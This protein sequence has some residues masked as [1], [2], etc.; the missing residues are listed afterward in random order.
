MLTEHG[1]VLVAL[2]D[3]QWLDPSSAGVLQIA[4]RRLRDEPVGVLATLRRAPDLAAPFELERTFPEGRL[5]LLE[6]RP[7]SLSAV[8]SLLEQRL[9]LELT[10][11]ELAR[12][13]E[14]TAGNPFFALE[15]GRELVRTGTRPAPGQPLRVPESLQEL[16]GG[17]L[18][19]LP[20][21]TLDVLL[22]V[23]AL[24]RPTVEVVTAAYGDREPVLRSFEE[25]AEEGVLVLD[26]ADIRFAHPLLA[27]ICYERAPLWK[28]R[29]VHRALAGVVT[30]VEERARHLALASEGPDA[31]IAADLDAAAEHAAARGATAAA[32]GLYE[33]AAELTPSD[34][35]LARKRRLRAANFH[36]LSGEQERAV[37][38]L[39]QLLAEVPP[40]VER[41]D[42]LF[43][44]ASV[45]KATI[46]T[47]IELCEE[48][49]TNAAGDD[50]RSARILALRGLFHFNEPNVQAYLADARAALEKAERAG[51]PAL[52]ATAIAHAGH[53]ETWAAE[54]TPGLLERGAEIEGRLGLTLE[55]TTSPRT[56]LARLLM[57]LGEI[58]RP[59]VML[60]ELEAGASARGDE[61]TRAHVLWYLSLLEWLAGRWQLALDHAT[62]ADEAGLDRRRGWWV[63]RVKA[64]IEAD[65]GLV[66]EAR[67]SA[68]VGLAAAHAGS[69]EAFRILTLGV[70][71]RLELARGNLE[72]A[73]SYL[74]DLPGWLLAGGMNDPTLPVWA[75]AIETLVA[76]GE[77][78]Q[79]G[80]YLEPLRVTCS[81][82]SAA[83]RRWRACSA[84]AACSL[85][86][87]ETSP[88]AIATMERAPCRAARPTLAV[89]A[90]A[91]RCSASA[92]Y[93]GR[94]SRRR[95]RGRRSSRRSPSS[96]SSVPASGPRRHGRS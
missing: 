14:A 16:L 37:A 52:V 36:R 2:D 50:T 47:L 30:D 78:E 68:E 19:R 22:Q 66:E 12:V 38:L 73:G 28:R 86:R 6:V 87:R 31:A 81:S 5:G 85:P 64:L 88:A 83:N 90:R 15:L 46:P 51:D 53:A 60:E 7:L 17:R 40:G 39:E 96:R 80:G 89:R 3:V 82:A 56:Y 24:A 42:V 92:R 62:A 74:R 93:A 65:L 79:A 13:H 43:G 63:G 11:P 33:R 48:A 55:Y 29:A 23:A 32:A 41:A 58:E 4:F 21:D 44:L 26:G 95:P 59:R 45:W 1:P 25:A 61:V 94:R 77:L 34:P 84:A 8:H 10:H 18:A 20:G 72:A 91:A 54:I 57:R 69:S 70:L 75:D 35:S 67:A 49:L 9:G 71:G 76:L 27:S